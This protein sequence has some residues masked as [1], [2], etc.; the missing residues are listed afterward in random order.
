MNEQL[1]LPHRRWEAGTRRRI[2]QVAGTVVLIAAL[3]IA[4]LPSA[5]TLVVFILITLWCHGPLSPFL[6]AAYEPVLLGYG[7]LLPPL[8]LAIT[9]AVASTAIEYFNY[10]LYQKLLRF[11][12]LDRILRSP[13]TRRLVRSFLSRPFVT[14]WLV[15]LTPL[16]DWAARI[17]ATHSGYS[18]RRYLAAVLLARL[19]RFWFLAAIGFHLELGAG[20]VLSIVAASTVVMLIGL[21]RRRPRLAS[22]KAAAPASALLLAGLLSGPL[23]LGSLAAQETPI[24]LAGP[25]MGVSMDRF[26]YDGS[27]LMAMSYRFST[28]RPGGIGAELGVSLFPQTLPAG[29]LALAPDLGV[30]YNI[31]GP[32]GS[33]LIKAGGSA[34]TAVGTVG[35]LFVP[36][37]HVGG[38]LIVQTGIRSALRVDLIRHYYR[39]SGG[40]IQPAWSVGVGFAILP[41]KSS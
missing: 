22:S 6:P 35:A 16:P 8:L 39:P 27:G 26:M 1:P 33:L 14:V 41:R 7:R 24:R 30:A 25:A 40:E 37:F 36:G 21:Y 31:P 10:H 19:P 13:P 5:T 9:G 15:V 18:V 17:L 2:V 3:C 4:L 29:V 12:G 32:G 28:L 11:E 38:A 23:A 34:I 20:V